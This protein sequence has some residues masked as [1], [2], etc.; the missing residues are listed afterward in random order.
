MMAEHLIRVYQSQTLRGFA[1]VLVTADTAA[2]AKQ[3][4]LDAANGDLD[5]ADGDRR[6][7]LPDGTRFHLD[8][9]DEVVDGE[10]W[11]EVVTGEAA[12]EALDNRKAPE[13]QGMSLL[14]IEPSAPQ[15]AR[16]DIAGMIVE[17]IQ[18][19]DGRWLYRCPELH[20]VNARHWRGPY[21]TERLA[22]V[23]LQSKRRVPRL[24]AKQ[25]EAK[26]RQG[27][28]EIIGGRTLILHLDPLTGATILTPFELLEDG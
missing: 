2:Q 1:D 9:E 22:L 8:P 21:D 18:Q 13:R 11:A 4:V 19:Q 20:P 14:P 23:D 27:Y 5:D 26:R 28:L 6:Y 15:A 12:I 7:L 25:V 17:T 3:I 16:H 10:I 24:T